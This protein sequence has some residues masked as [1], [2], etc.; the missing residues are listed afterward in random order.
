MVVLQGNV[1][2]FLNSSCD[3][4][5]ETQIWMTAANEEQQI[6]IFALR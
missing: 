1:S 4:N 5:C 3:A 2:R 6:G